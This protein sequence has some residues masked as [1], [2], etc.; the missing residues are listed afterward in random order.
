M[1]DLEGWSRIVDEDD[2]QEDEECSNVQTIKRSNARTL[3]RL[4]A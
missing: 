2:D 3:K 1:S 4:N